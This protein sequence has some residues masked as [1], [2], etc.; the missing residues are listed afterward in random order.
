MT[1][2]ELENRL[3]VAKDLIKLQEQSLEGR[4]H[5]IKCLLRQQKIARRRLA[6]WLEE[7]DLPCKGPRINCQFATPQDCVNCGLRYLTGVNPTINELRSVE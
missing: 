4:A 7:K 6:N 1:K 3:K 2:K 5:D